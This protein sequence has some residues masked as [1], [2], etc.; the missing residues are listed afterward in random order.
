VKALGYRGEA[1]VA[2]TYYA[3]F[4]WAETVD[5]WVSLN[6]PLVHLLQRVPEEKP[7]VPCRIGIADPSPLEKLTEGCLDHCQGIVGQ[8]LARL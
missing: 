6:R 7:G 1:E 4:P 5:L 3:D 2:I 8:I